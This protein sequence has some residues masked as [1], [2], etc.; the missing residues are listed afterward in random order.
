MNRYFYNVQARKRQVK[1]L[2]GK[3]AIGA[4]GAVTLDA[5]ASSGI[6][7]ITK[8]ATGTYT[9]V[10]D[11]K[12]PQL[13]GFSAMLLDDDINQIACFQLTANAVSTSGSLTFKCLAAT[14][15]STTTLIAANPSSGATLLFTVSVNNTSLDA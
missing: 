15:S 6:T 1:L 3:A 14:N 5:P 13:V 4:S 12:V 11:G 10:L 8:D 7:S 2:H 9:I